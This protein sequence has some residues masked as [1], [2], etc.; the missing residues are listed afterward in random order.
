MI[1]FILG[2]YKLLFH[3]KFEKKL[4]K[5]LKKKDATHSAAVF[6]Y[7]KYTKNFS[8]ENSFDRP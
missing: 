1:I 2:T 3:P 6:K 4:R 7:S 8:E 5:K